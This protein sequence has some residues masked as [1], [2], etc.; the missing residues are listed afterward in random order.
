MF[1]S[2]TCFCCFFW[3]PFFALII[4]V[5]LSQMLSSNAQLSLVLHSHL[6]NSLCRKVTGFY[7][8]Y[9]VL[10]SIGTSLN[11]SCWGSFLSGGLI[12]L[13]RNPLISC[14]GVEQKREEG[15]LFRKW[16]LPTLF[17]G[18]TPPLAVPS[19]RLACS[20]QSK[21]PGSCPGLTV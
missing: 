18:L 7:C 21:P 9:E 19:W 1:S 16:D 10:A 8:L 12:S 13:E 14:V 20:P 17:W 15:S 4:S 11:V 5:F 3:I 2:V 6:R